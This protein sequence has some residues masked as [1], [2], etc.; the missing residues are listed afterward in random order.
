MNGID[1]LNINKEIYICYSIYV[2]Y[3]FFSLIN[4][5]YNLTNKPQVIF[6]CIFVLIFKIYPP[7]VIHKYINTLVFF[8]NTYNKI[9]SNPI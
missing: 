8:Y 7:K 4:C 1:E 5:F 3:N 6:V 2:I 9:S